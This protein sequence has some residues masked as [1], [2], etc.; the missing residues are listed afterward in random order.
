MYMTTQTVAETPQ[1]QA[2]QLVYAAEATT[3]AAPYDEVPNGW[4]V[5]RY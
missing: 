1:H 4:F 2:K 5:R 3:L